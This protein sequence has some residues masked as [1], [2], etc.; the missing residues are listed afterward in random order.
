MASNTP[1]SPNELISIAHAGSREPA[2]AV[3]AETPHLLWS[4]DREIW[5]SYR[6]ASGWSEPVRVAAGEQP[7][8]A[9]APDGQLHA[10]FVNQFAGNAEIYY[11]WWNGVA[12]SLPQ[13]VSHSTGASSQP[14]IAVGPGGTPRAVWAD[15][16]AGHSAIYT[17]RLEEGRWLTGP[18]ASARGSAPA[19][20]IT[21]QNVAYILWQ[22]RLESSQ[23]FEVFCTF[24]REDG[25]SMP[26]N[27]SSSAERH[28][29]QP[30]VATNI[31]GGC[32]LLW[33]E[34]L[35]GVFGIQ[36]A[37]RR[38]N[39]WGAPADVSATDADCRAPRIA[40]NRQG[41]LQA[42]WQ[43][44]PTLFHRVRPPDYDAEWWAPEVATDS[45][46]GL[47]EVAFAVARS[48][49]THV[50]WCG[51]DQASTYRLYYLQRQPVF[52][53]TTFAPVG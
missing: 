21:P 12:W 31:Q 52:K 22:D 8:L 18:L 28:S 46:G 45:C 36:H 20:A 17:G 47:S 10:V 25:W 42:L 44:G 49:K 16:S 40:A 34:E 39:G 29:L 33:Q 3:A 24:S 41:F 15:N 38:P 51:A 1:W 43:Q 19:L 27:I 5:H 30:C 13:N 6:G 35:A 2:L 23:R 11:V 14:A 53:Y 32:H 50:V 37:D 9:A 26:E 4:R 7:A 48:G